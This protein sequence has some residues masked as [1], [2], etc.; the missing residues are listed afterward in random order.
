MLG[1]QPVPARG[2]PGRQSAAPRQHRTAQ[3]AA[4]EQGGR[5]P[6]GPAEVARDRAHQPGHAQQ[7]QRRQHAL[8]RRDRRPPPGPYAPRSRTAA[9]GGRARGPDA[10]TAAVGTP[11]ARGRALGRAPLRAPR[12]RHRDHRRLGGDLVQRLRQA[13]RAPGRRLAHRLGPRLGQPGRRL[14][15]QGPHRLLD[16]RPGGRPARR[17]RHARETAATGSPALASGTGLVG[18][19][20]VAATAPEEPRAPEAD[21]APADASLAPPVP[22]AHPVPRRP[23]G[24]LGV[25]APRPFRRQAGGL[26]AH[27]LREPVL[28]LLPRPLR[29]PG[30]DVRHVR[31]PQ[32][33]RD[34]VH[35]GRQPQLR[36][37]PAGHERAQGLAQFAHP[38]P[39]QGRQRQ[40]RRA[41]L[42]VLAEREPVLVQQP[43]QVVQHL[44][45]GVRRQPV[46][47]VEDD[48]HHLRVARQ[49]PQIA[50]VQHGVRVLLRVH[51]PDHRVHQPEQPVHLLPVAHRGRVVVGQV[52]QDEP[53]QRRVVRAHRLAAGPGRDAEP[54]QHP[55][56]AVRPRAGDGHRGRRPTHPGL[57]ELRPREGVEQRRLPAARGSREGHHR[58][59]ERVPVPGRGLLQHPTRLGERAPVEPGPGEA[60]QLAQ[61]VQSGPQGQSDGRGGGGDARYGRGRL[62]DRGPALGP[63]GGFGPDAARDQA[64]VPEAVSATGAA[65]TGVVR[66][67]GTLTCVVPT[68]LCRHAS[69]LSFCSRDSAAMSSTWWSGVISRASSGVARR[70]RSASR[71][72]SRQSSSSCPP[73]SRSRRARCAP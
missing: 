63:G 15:G 23:A 27:R 52:Q 72:R 67:G 54:L 6:P 29:Q 53:A 66:G 45:R 42:A 14:V 13:L 8:P 47:L 55:V 5:R 59:V 73:R 12:A 33:R 39:G 68:V 37:A 24:P 28:E 10:R 17:R 56:R 3:A 11:H 35:V 40:H 71:T 22:V 60:H 4:R 57:R 16:Q 46:H 61:R 65:G 44:V 36:R 50:L 18:V 48:E 2:P 1:L 70:S 21:Q 49:R 69:H 62:G 41:R 43:P 30:P 19:G 58:Q 26:G 7:L 64:V 25:A 31:R 9:P 51:H 32:A 34:A 38:G 20:V